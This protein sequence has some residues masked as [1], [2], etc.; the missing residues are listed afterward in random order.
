EEVGGADATI[1]EKWDALA[2]F[3]DMSSFRAGI[4][5]GRIRGRRAPRRGQAA[6]GLDQTDE[7][8]TADRKAP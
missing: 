4:P 1:A 8:E 5:K 3:V 6:G 2:L 7:P